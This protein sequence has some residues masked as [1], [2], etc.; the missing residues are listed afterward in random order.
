MS[1]IKR[2]L[3]RFGIYIPITLCIV[4][5]F[6][7]LNYRVPTLDDDLYL[8]E[9]A[10]ITETLVRG[11]WF[12]HYGVGIHGFLFKLPVAFVFLLTGPSLI[13]A[14]IWNIFIASVSLALFY[15]ILVKV[16]KNANL[17]LLGTLFLFT[18][19]QFLLNLPTYM[20]EIP[21]LFSFLLFVFSV[22]N[23]GYG[24]LAGLSLL[25]VL[26][27][28]ESVFFMISSGLIIAILINSYKGFNLRSLHKMFT[29]GVLVF[30]PSITYVL[31]MIFT[32]AIPLNTSIFTVVPGVTEGGVEYQL[33]HF[34]Q[35]S[36]TDSV[37]RLKSPEAKTIENIIPVDT[38]EP[39]RFQKLLS[40]SLSYIG[41]VLYPRTFSFLS[42]PLIIL[43][44][45]LF[46]AVYIFK[47]ALLRRKRLLSL[48]PLLTGSFLAIYIFR[49][50]FDRYL[51]PITPIIFIFFLFFVK[52]FVHRRKIFFLAVLS[53]G[54]LSFLSLLF[55][56]D[57]IA[58]KFLL[59]LAVFSSLIIY[60]FMVHNR[61]IGRILLLSFLSVLTF[62]VFAFYFYKEGQYSKSA[63]WG[64]EYEVHRV[65]SYFDKEEKIF[66]NDIG[67]DMLL[68]TYRG[69]LYS[70]PEW[71]WPLKD[72]VP[73]KNSLRVYERFNTYLMDEYFVIQEL[74]YLI[75]NDIDK[76]VLIVSLIPDK[77]FPYQEKLPEYLEAEWLELED[78]V[79]LK[80]K[81]MYIFSVQK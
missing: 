29:R 4:V 20:R 25:L 57:Y 23:S 36:A 28:K 22:M 47:D 18:N 11:D 9:T 14:S 56:A 51:F 21:V 52:D 39:G 19:F 24:I 60:G 2:F 64:R 77:P 68:Y 79:Q 62:S 46:S 1:D 38:Q 8:Y 31:I 37:V 26:D 43:V 15:K 65:V 13:I 32:S 7:A 54:L 49:L 71:K 40:G 66:I 74:E 3:E 76:I 6:L 70:P 42:I 5:G 55:E 50:S 59:N 78:R 16:L 45:A 33:K 80:N 10:L 61:E 73:R 81:D 58:I 72:W 27:A 34:R 67:W 69:D 63:T 53:A 30:L 12:G 48:L 17:A 41:K 75:D 44:P 35:L